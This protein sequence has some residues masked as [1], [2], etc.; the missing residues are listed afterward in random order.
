MTPTDTM[1]EADSRS[2]DGSGPRNEPNLTG[3]DEGVD[4]RESGSG[5]LA[6]GVG[7]AASPGL[8]GEQQA[9]Q[10]IGGSGGADGGGGG[11]L[12]ATNPLGFGLDFVSG[13]VHVTM[14]DRQAGTVWWVRHLALEVPDVT[15]PFDVRG[16]A[17]RFRHRRTRLRELDLSLDAETCGL[18]LS[19]LPDLAAFGF[20]SLSVEFRDGVASASG[21]M[22]VGERTAEFSVQIRIAPC[23]QGRL[24]IRLGRWQ[25]YGYVPVPPTLI[26][27]GLAAAAGVRLLPETRSSGAPHPRVYLDALGVVR[28]DLRM[29]VLRWLLPA[30]GWRLPDV[31]GAPVREVEV[32]DEGVRV[33]WADRSDSVGG[34]AEVSE[35]CD[36]GA[37]ALDSA[38]GA[39]CR[40]DLLKAQ[41][42]IEHHLAD[43][44]EDR[45]AL[46]LKME[47]LACDPG[48]LTEARRLARRLLA[49]AEEAA[50]QHPGGS[51]G[52]RTE[53]SI[54][55]ARGE[56]LLA[57]GGD[58]S[59][60]EWLDLAQRA[61]FVLANSAEE[62][63]EA[64]DAASR[65]AALAA[66]FE[67]DG[68][69]AGALRATMACG[70]LLS[71]PSP[72]QA[73]SWF[74]RALAL[75][76]DHPDAVHALS[77]LLR[78]EG[79]HQELVR[80]LR[81][82]LAGAT[83]RRERL[84]A[85]LSL[86]RVYLDPMKD[87]LRARAEFERAVRLDDASLAAWDGLAEA[88]RMSGRFD[89]ELHA[90]ERVVSLCEAR[91][92]ER[93]TVRA[94]LR[95]ADAWARQG[96]LEAALQVS[97]AL[98]RDYPT[99][100]DVLAQ[101]GRLCAAA[102]RWE[103]AA[104]SL[105][106]LLASG[107]ISAERREEIALDL[108]ELRATGIGDLAG[109]RIFVEAALAGSLSERGLRLAISIAE[110]EGRL[111]DLVDYLAQLAEVLPEDEEG[112]RERGAVT[113]RR[114]DILA[115]QLGDPR[116]AIGLLDAY[117]AEVRA[118]AASRAPEPDASLRVALRR[119]AS[120]L[121]EVGEADEWHQAVRQLAEWIFASGFVPEEEEIRLMLRLA[122]GL[123]AGSDAVPSSG[124]ARAALRLLRRI[125]SAAPQDPRPLVALVELLDGP[126]EQ[127]E[128]EGLLERLVHVTERKG[129]GQRQAS[130]LR[131]LGRLRRGQGR[132]E[133]ARAAFRAAL[134]LLDDPGILMVEL[135]DVAF[136]LG[137]TDEAERVLLGS[138]EVEVSTPGRALR[139]LRLGQIAL[140]RGDLLGA[141]TALSAALAADDGLG[142]SE[143]MAAY[144]SIQEAYS[145]SERWADGVDAIV[146]MAE[147]EHV[148]L[149]PAK[150]AEARFAAAEILRRRL[151]VAAEALRH[152][153]A[154]LEATPDHLGALN[155]LTVVAAGQGD[156]PR[157]ATLLT[158][159]C[160]LLRD[161][162]DE[163]PLLAELGELY[164]TRLDQPQA[165]RRAYEEVLARAPDHREALRFLASDT[166]SCGELDSARTF[167]QRLL[168]LAEADARIDAVRSAEDLEACHRSLTDIARAGGDLETVARHLESLIALGSVSVGEIEELEAIY[169]SLE[170]WEELA[171]V[172][173]RRSELAQEGAEGVEHLVR[174]A[175]LLAAPLGRPGEA[176]AV[177][178]EVLREAPARVE[179][180]VALE[181]LLSAD[182]SAAVERRRLLERL[183]ETVESEEDGRGGAPGG[184]LSRAHL[185]HEL[186]WL[187]RT[188]LGEPRAGYQV[189]KEALEAGCEEPEFLGRLAQVAREENDA[190]V[191]DTALGRVAAHALDRAAVVE[192]RLEQARLRLDALR[193]PEGAVEALSHLGEEEH[194]AQTLFLL[195]C[196][197]ESSGETALAS[198]IY[199]QS[200]SL[201]STHSE[202][203][204]ER[205]AIEAVLRLAAA[206]QGDLDR[207]GVLASRLLERE[208]SHEGALS[209]RRTVA[210]RSRRLDAFGDAIEAWAAHRVE[211]GDEEGAAEALAR[212]AGVCLMHGR[213][214]RGEAAARKALEREPAHWLARWRLAEARAAAGDFGAALETLQELARRV[215]R[216]P[217]GPSP[218]DHDLDSRREI[219]AEGF[220]DQGSLYLAIGELAAEWG[221][222]S[223]ALDAYR[224]GSAR[225][226]GGG[227]RRG[228]QAWADLARREGAWSDAAEALE[229][230]VR[231]G[232]SHRERLALA[233]AYERLGRVED[234]LR[235]INLLAPAAS[236]GDS[237]LDRATRERQRALLEAAGRYEELARTLEEE[238]LSTSERSVRA[239]LY[240]EAA[241]HYLRRAG[242]IE[243]GERC[244]LLALEADSLH[245]GAVERL[246]RMAP[247]GERSR[248][249]DEALARSGE[250]AR[251]AE[252][253]AEGHNESRRA[254]LLWR[255]VQDRWQHRPGDREAAD[256]VGVV[257]D[258]DP[259]RLDA[260]D[261]AESVLRERGEY[262][263]L[264]ARLE[265][266]I[267]ARGLLAGERDRLRLRLAR[268][269]DEGLDSPERAVEVVE[270]VWAGEG[271]MPEVV[272]QAGTMY[273]DLL[274]RLSRMDEAAGVLRQM[275]AQSLNPERLLVRA[276]EAARE[277]DVSPELC[278]T[279]T[280]VLAAM[281]DGEALLDPLVEVAGLC[282]RSG[283]L[284][285]QRRCLERLVSLATSPGA[286]GERLLELAR[287][288]VGAGQVDEAGMTLAVAVREDPSSVSIQL[289]R[290]KLA[291]QQEDLDT[292]RVALATAHDL[293]P[294]SEREARADVSLERGRVEA[295][296]GGDRALARRYAWQ[297]AEETVH[298][299]RK[300]D[301]LRQVLRLS[302]EGED[303]AGVEEVLRG[304]LSLGM[305]EPEE[306]TRLGGL[307][308]AR[309]AWR[310]ARQVYEHL[311]EAVPEDPQARRKLAQA[312][313][314][315]GEWERAER[316][317][318]TA[319]ESYAD[320]GERR[321]AAA[322]LREAGAVRL[323]QSASDVPA[324]E[325][326]LRAMDYD[327][328]DEEAHARLV[329]LA[330][331]A[332]E[333]EL[334]IEAWNRR[335]PVLAPDA[336]QAAYREMA[337]LAGESLKDP[338]REA[339]FLAMGLAVGPDASDLLSR[340]VRY[341]AGREEW[342][343]ARDYGRRLEAV[344][345]AP[346]DLAHEVHGLL[347]H[348]ALL[349]EDASTA[350]VHLRRALTAHP[351]DE[352][353]RAQMEVLLEQAGDA[354]AL[355]DLILEAAQRKEGRDRAWA[356][357]R[358]ADLSAGALEDAARAE[359]L[360]QEAVQISPEEVSLRERFADLLASR[361]RWGPLCEQL[362]VLHTQ[363]RGPARAVVADRLADL[364][365]HRL[366]DPGR[367][368]QYRRMAVSDAPADVARLR[369]L[370]D[371]LAAERR[372]GD[373][374]EVL[375]E[376][377]HTVVLDGES[378]AG[379]YA[380]LGR[381]YLE[382]L[383]E[384]EQALRVFERARTRGA[385]TP[386][387]GRL[388]AE[389]Y[390]AS[391]RFS[392]LVDLLAELAE[393][394]EER[395][396]VRRLQVQ[397][398][399][400]LAD[401][402]GFP[403]EAA[404]VL[405]ALFREAPE[406]RRK[407]GEMA[408]RLRIR[409]ESF[410][411][412]LEILGEELAAAP[413]D[414]QIP[415]LLARGELLESPLGR[416]EEALAVYLGVL[417]SAPRNQE[418][419]LRVARLLYERGEVERSLL[420]A[421]S[422]AQ[423]AD[424]KLAGIARLFAGRASLD[425]D[426][427]EEAVGHFEAALQEDPTDVD[428]LGEL[429]HLYTAQ[430]QWERLADCMGRL[431]TLTADPREKSR[432][433]YR[434]A[435]VFRDM[436]DRG[437][438]ALRCLREAVQADGDNEE[439]VA[440]LRDFA[441]ERGDW[442]TSLALLARQL[443]GEHE[444]S[445]RARLLEKR[446]DILEPRLGRVDEAVAALEEALSLGGDPP[447]SLRQK[448]ARLYVAR[449][450]WG[451]AAEI[452]HDLARRAQAETGRVAGLLNAAGLYERAERVGDARAIYQSVLESSSGRLLLGAAERL[453]DLAADDLDRARILSHLEGR[454]DA[455]E[456]GDDALEANRLCLRLAMEIGR[457]DRALSHAEAIL[458]EQPADRLAF[459]HLRHALEA[460]EDWPALEG[461]LLRRL[462]HASIEEAPDLLGGLGR[463]QRD[464]LGDLDG[465]ADT[466]DRLLSSHP[467]DLVALDARA[468]L[469]F[470]RGEFS[471]AGE[472]Y[473]RMEGRPSSLD[474]PTLACR[475][476][477]ISEA[478]GRDAEALVH[479]RQAL[480]ARPNDIQAL[481]GVARLEIL[482]GHPRGALEPMGRL[483]ECVAVTDPRRALSYG[484]HEVRLWRELG[485]PE[486]G[487]KRA[488]ALAEQAPDSAEV[489]GLLSD[490][491]EQEGRWA[492]LAETLDRLARLESD[493]AVRARLLCDR[494]EVLED[495][496]GDS[497]SASGCYLE[498]GDLD[499][500][501]PRVA[502]RLAT[503]LLRLG[504][505]GEAVDAAA[506]VSGPAETVHLGL[507]RLAHAVGSLLAGGGAAREAPRVMRAPE[508]ADVAPAEAAILLAAV[509]A[510]LAHSGD[511]VRGLRRV[512][513][514]VDSALG[515]AFLPRWMAAAE[516]LAAERSTDVGIRLLLARLMARVGE[517]TLG[518]Q[519][520]AALRFLLPE[521]GAQMDAPEPRPVRSA[522]LYRVFGPTV[523]AEAK[524]ALRTLLTELHPALGR[525][526]P[527]LD[528]SRLGAEVDEVSAPALF[529]I[530][531]E[532]RGTLRSGPVGA[533]FARSPTRPV[534]V[535]YSL[536]PVLLMHPDI[537]TWPSARVRFLIARAL[538][539]CRSGTALLLS[540][541][542]DRVAALLD[543]VAA[544]FDVPMPES[545]IVEP[546]WMDRIRRA[547]L[548]PGL[549]DNATR[550]TLQVAFFKYYREAGDLQSYLRA[551][552][553]ASD[554]F[555]LLA[556]GRLDEALWALAA[557]VGAEGE[558]GACA[559]AG[560]VPAT[561]EERR[562][563]VRTHRELETLLIYG[564]SSHYLSLLRRRSSLPRL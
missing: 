40:G 70:R 447:P 212:L 437:G 196:A 549:Y 325:L 245:E 286:R 358:A 393:R 176:A 551:A 507:A 139:D 304:L 419:Q 527:R 502:V 17:G 343:V 162:D 457:T 71:G 173:R 52:E 264:A 121:S 458:A 57:P 119:L 36:R 342:S 499:P 281:P 158:R 468:D 322:C 378:A 152:Y 345:G 456:E 229:R 120:L 7:A 96:E 347:A 118:A 491:Q 172:L 409:G 174:L 267:S 411:G 535:V 484:I 410:E 514:L 547:D 148:D 34:D 367:A 265:A 239:E 385:L 259:G 194:T 68:D 218:R 375:E 273:L 9:S 171:V 168:L 64:S 184:R 243:R 45:Q 446:A 550:E 503:H 61:L 509:A 321:E 143:R 559:A 311:R 405:L 106:R 83:D 39:L 505:W 369:A 414:E 434:R 430:G 310:E 452:E 533:A 548:G 537:A 203:D 435:L 204:A 227:L 263:S 85:H 384:P 295:Q 285:G 134:D 157:V 248:E 141:S 522:R 544:T 556:S 464:R 429:V 388:L 104:D 338:D 282:K 524:V 16:G 43:S 65:Y 477:R 480:G 356:L 277:R 224:R 37:G 87:A 386:R 539:Q 191:L 470:R 182:P 519:H 294:E 181:R 76:P 487:L 276:L 12:R 360:Y 560:S 113:I 268:V 355:Q 107:G 135:G 90:Q 55:Q 147:D 97:G 1:V 392:D 531:E 140:S 455:F 490:L 389:L 350:R 438:E 80:L 180:L 346:M 94:R 561:W 142:P 100:E 498:A 439:A 98:L 554:R 298:A 365:E 114:A 408:R 155:G 146:A 380:L 543:A 288:Q 297:A 159:K 427:I 463:L 391:G 329:E 129:D 331:A 228:L 349:R 60:S 271:G 240:V 344:G 66:L 526:A 353:M 471:E 371:L 167:Y 407:L 485:E 217:P 515:R 373:L 466:F 25:V 292:V 95:V 303:R 244:L 202:W 328:E 54:E 112:R 186:G 473:A 395:S 370:S 555:G 545:V 253:A 313:R 201:A 214:L 102:S 74:E 512:F 374:V 413:P 302:R 130:A 517:G 521:G 46:C 23:S 366:S 10:P 422:A 179:A 35:D 136:R 250:N 335:L 475:M 237:D 289:E 402:L 108:A 123:R 301:A 67:R 469:A 156:W 445:R 91:G 210:L 3:S 460:R 474:A 69:L 423:G 396:E 103:E 520:A 84:R 472:L 327:P 479:Y 110:G 192:A 20:S 236:T 49:W 530:L 205:R 164:A 534:E 401:R 312:L 231:D 48:G 188:E 421:E 415:I 262:E 274:Y 82:H 420:H 382:K 22:A 500:G 166:L 221:E 562:R 323:G 341:H 465:A 309:S 513:D 400:V 247:A 235:Q 516:G 305:A 291:E 449:Q 241:D 5:G 117:V 115:D 424:A 412:A 368:L 131:D 495:H 362:E 300:A 4:R 417:E 27:V 178:R 88:Y 6:R 78:S 518:N 416:A 150:R 478:I 339:A 326:L 451:R 361:E 50:E 189:L 492:D 398:A 376:A 541:S 426:R 333:L 381:A 183:L 379:F 8:R 536:P 403:L 454:M 279:L 299:D 2:T 314:A 138:S 450:D 21:K 523:P 33:V 394:S 336:Q 529:E 56:A 348:E 238:A 483:A 397:R 525:V 47:L 332:G 24:E 200:A 431:L 15:F 558:A 230:L 151:G 257:L 406:R 258:L 481:E 18:H 19:A 280:D 209:F 215:E 53:G 320:A 219:S 443:E 11:G 440:A 249:V 482:A 459:L 269:L 432:L 81:S 255:L 510:G 528:P 62:Q 538:E 425:L 511:P 436:L 504:R 307:C 154:V 399:R 160:A 494:G 246:L 128:R 75:S 352:E 254:G 283:E 390:E 93:A 532:L 101:H 122:D 553:D 242:L 137:E 127:V 563:L 337:R 63:G 363:V 222:A 270:A 340:L 175:G 461:L 476:G 190:V 387:S 73:V 418:A 42:H 145:R 315:T 357:A 308:E 540:L 324:L 126:D 153:E 330:R 377:L 284:A 462:Q 125:H 232:G 542:L 44:P 198:D 38:L 86:G 177:W 193:Q 225:L 169:E 351:E 226:Q 453:A 29:E 13:R 28:F 272:E 318:L 251:G 195:A 441:L 319:A 506:K 497:S 359:T 404:S 59:A 26:G 317:L 132:L 428:T 467:D 334:C 293:L 290:A 208:P 163:V 30:H 256:W 354:A 149:S 489:L 207:S 220:S 133:E 72:D 144:E 51:P 442:E 109:A 216:L 233:E 501:A 99:H 266:A 433:W 552:L 165:A 170:R 372:W 32:S 261:A 252:A 546:S 41:E 508:V 31:S 197:R 105:E 493:P 79:R 557:Q 211:Q 296:L 564:T 187:L 444:P 124:G 223:V 111:I 89:R 185:L 260:L 496:L 287:A 234:A 448:L 206:E 161:S 278:S 199:A 486:M 306:L 213:V 77:G 364:A 383:Q 116:H 316:E 92:D 275:A 14:R 488:V 58:S